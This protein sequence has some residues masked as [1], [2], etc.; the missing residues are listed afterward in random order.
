[1]K[2]YYKLWLI[3]HIIVGSLV[4][5]FTFI[6]V[7]KEGGFRGI[8]GISGLLVLL[9]LISLSASGTIDLV[10]KCNKKYAMKS[11]VTSQWV[12]RVSIHVNYINILNR[13]LVG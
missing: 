2:H 10:Y 6:Y 11:Y 7:L 12:H 4:T 5:T 13:Y 3:S 9:M 1:M 8:K